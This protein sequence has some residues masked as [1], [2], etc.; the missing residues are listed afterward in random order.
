MHTVRTCLFVAAAFSVVP[1]FSPAR[2]Q[3]QIPDTLD[4]KYVR[5]GLRVPP[6]SANRLRGTL[7]VH[8]DSIF[9]VVSASGI[10]AT[11]S[12]EAVR[13]L[14]IRVGVQ[15]AGRSGFLMGA[16]LGGLT[17]GI[18]AGVQ[19]A[20]CEAYFCLGVPGAFGVGF[21]VGAVPGGGVGWLIGRTRSADAWER[22]PLRNIH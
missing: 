14:D 5:V 11:H 22:Y 10:A 16:L 13:T 21:V 18:A 7:R 1:A 15:R 19:E 6:A 17:V 8:D 9:T 12:L 4:G 2:L 3:A 20:G